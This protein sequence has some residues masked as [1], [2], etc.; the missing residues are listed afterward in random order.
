LIVSQERDFTATVVASPIGPLT[1]V[2]TARGLSHVLFPGESPPPAVNAEEQAAPGKATEVLAAAAR[3]LA[4]YFAGTRRHFDLAL[5]PQGTPFQLAAWQALGEIPYGETISYGE[6]ARRLGRLGS[7]RAVGAA[8]GRNPL[9]IVVPCHRV[10]GASGK[11][12][13][14]G[15]GLEAK[16]YLLNLEVSVQM[17]G[18]SR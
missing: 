16:R 2:A 8:N 3:Q 11:L 6:Q 1:L 4:E 13:G 10:V 9:P 15:G 18:G 5:D 14:F 17:Q 7:A 12:V